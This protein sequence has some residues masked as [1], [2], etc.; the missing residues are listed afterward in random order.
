MQRHLS[1][2]RLTDLGEDAVVAVEVHRP[3]G[4]KNHDDS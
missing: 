2:R 1:G 4:P 3:E